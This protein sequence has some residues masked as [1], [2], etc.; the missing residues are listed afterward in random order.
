MIWFAGLSADFCG[1]ANFIHLKNWSFLICL[2]RFDDFARQSAESAVF[3]MRNN[4]KRFYLLSLVGV[5]LLI[6]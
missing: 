6:V 1:F 2:N 5:L 3:S 4:H